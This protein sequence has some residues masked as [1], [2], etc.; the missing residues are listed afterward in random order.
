MTCTVFSFIA[1]ADN[2]SSPSAPSYVPPTITES[3]YN[4]LS[5]PTSVIEPAEQ[6]SQPVQPVQPVQIP[7][8]VQPVQNKTISYVYDV[9]VG[10][11]CEAVNVKSSGYTNG[12]CQNNAT[13]S[14][15][16]WYGTC[17]I[18]AMHPYEYDNFT[19]QQLKTLLM[20]D[21][22]F[23]EVNTNNMLIQ[24]EKCGSA[25]YTYNARSGLNFLYIE[26][27]GDGKGLMKR[28]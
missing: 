19:L 26:R 20:A 11:V 25:M 7:Q 18:N 5:E 28:G 2:S 14:F 22:L 4:G 15:I 23:D 6:V 8:P 21:L 16:K 10:G 3:S 12:A 1:C 17:D 9:V 24:A 27:V 13:E